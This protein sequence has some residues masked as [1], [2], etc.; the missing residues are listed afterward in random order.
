MK[1]DYTILI[2]EMH[3]VALKL[4]S[5]ADKM[6]KTEDGYLFY[7]NALLADDPLPNLKPN[8]KKARK[9]RKAS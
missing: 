6:R 2:E 3:E 9:K 5:V 8:P 7:L 1:S 4:L